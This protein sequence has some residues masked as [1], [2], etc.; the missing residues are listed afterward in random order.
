MS[1]TFTP[2]AQERRRVARAEASVWIVRLHGPHRTPE[3]EA[4]FRQWLAASADNAAEFERVTSVWESAPH[5]CT[6]GL[7]RVTRWSEPKPKPTYRWAIAAS[8]IV[9]ITAGAWLASQLWLN[10]DYATGIGEQRTVPLDDGSRIA[11]NSDSEVKIEFTSDTRRVRLVHGEAFFDVAHN[12]AR[13]FIVVAGDHQVTAV[14]TA[15]EVRYD[16]GQVDVTLVEGKV[17]V[18][19][20]ESNP[21]DAPRE[22]SSSETGSVA[23]T[24]AG[25]YVM[26]PGERLHIARNTPVKVDEPRIDVVTAWRRGEVMLDNTPLSDAVAE[27][28]RYNKSALVIDEPRIAGLRVSGIYHTGDSEGFAQTVANL[29]GLHVSQAEHQIHL[30]SANTSP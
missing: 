15:F 23:K 19:R 30:S 10:P 13:P 25:G 22:L 9:A 5:A 17:N 7:P 12:T 6:A 2:S 21:Q 3:L 26:V 29:Y 14:G 16:L 4:G 27:M 11:L 1:A 20:A 18:T 24:V 8:V 28:N